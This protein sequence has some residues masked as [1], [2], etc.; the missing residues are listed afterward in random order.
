MACGTVHSGPRQPRGELV[1][2]VV[3]AGVAA[4]CSAMPVATAETMLMCTPHPPP[5]SV[6][7]AEQTHAKLRELEE[8]MLLQR[9]EYRKGI[10]CCGC[11]SISWVSSS[12]PDHLRTWEM[13]LS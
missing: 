3:Q 13:S 7:Q 4:A 1:M 2:S 10:T 8:E 6:R 12:L 5:C 9:Q 11:V